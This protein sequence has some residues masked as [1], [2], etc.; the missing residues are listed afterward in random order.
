MET[1]DAI[2]REFY[3]TAMFLYGK[4]D[5]LAILGSYGDEQVLQ[6]LRDWNESSPLGMVQAELKVV[7]HPAEE[8]GFWAEVPGFPG[9]VSEGETVEE[10]RINI[11]EAFEGVL[12]IM[13]GRSE[14]QCHLDP[15]SQKSS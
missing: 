3:K 15:S 6:M 14:V 9:C 7:I 12:E 2:I 8:G 4:S 10:A 5:L 13:Q 1:K 11:R